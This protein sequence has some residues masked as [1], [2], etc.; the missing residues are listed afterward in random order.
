MTPRIVALTAGIGQPSSSRLL[1][2]RLVSA[3][4]DALGDAQVQVVE[5]RE[6]ATEITNA[7][8][9][10]YVA[11]PLRE[12]QR[13]VAA[14]DGVIAV[15]PVFTASYSGLFKS[16]FDVLDRDA[17][18]GKPMLLGATGGTERHS[19]VLDLQMRPLFAY[20]RAIPVATA[21]YAAST[22][23]ARTELSQRIQAAAAE[24]ANA[25]D[26]TERTREEEFTSA[27]FE[28]L[29]GSLG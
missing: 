23:W 3:T 25:V 28:E 6:L 22:D 11:E 8:I 20:L 15:T 1:A 18:D 27:P 19:L 26:R 9:T 4:A 17:L 24:F 13:E 29:L 7:M 5:L 12:V 2:D 16:F 21:V 14:A 10:G